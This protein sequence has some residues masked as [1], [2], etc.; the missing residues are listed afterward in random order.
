[1]LVLFV[2][3][4]K[5][6]KTTVPSL[7]FTTCQSVL[8][9]VSVPLYTLKADVV[10]VGVRV[11]FVGVPVTVRVGVSTYISGVVKL[12]ASLYILLCPSLPC[13]VLTNTCVKVRPVEGVQ[14]VKL[15]FPS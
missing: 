2:V 8:R 3:L 13:F 4:F 11:T 6:S 1:M 7:T 5:L 14:L 10:N 12:M 15:L 9:C